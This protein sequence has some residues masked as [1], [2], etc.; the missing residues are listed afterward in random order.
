[1]CIFE[2]CLAIIILNLILCARQY[3]TYMYIYLDIKTMYMYMCVY[4]HIL[5]YS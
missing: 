1:M 5:Y 2:C 4:T 3:P